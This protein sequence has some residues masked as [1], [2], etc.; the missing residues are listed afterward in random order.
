MDVIPQ[1]ISTTVDQPLDLIRLCLNE[2]VLVKM[3]SEREV[4]GKLH[5]FDQHLNMVL[6]DAEETVT[7]AEFEES[8][9]EDVFKQVKRIIPMLFLRGDSVILVSPLLKTT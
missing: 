4:V 3:R 1:E 2:V 6:S 8:Q 7:I 9:C 5:A